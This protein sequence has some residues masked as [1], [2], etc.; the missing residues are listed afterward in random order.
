MYVAR[1]AL[2]RQVLPQSSCRIFSRSNFLGR[3]ARSGPISLLPSTPARTRFAPSPT[4]YVHIGSL[5]TALF[6]Y[7]LAKA[8][9][10]QFLVRVEDT[11]QVRPDTLLILMVNENK[12]RSD[13]WLETTRAR[14]RGEVVRRFELGR[15]QLGRRWEILRRRTRLQFSSHPNIIQALILEDLTD[16]ISR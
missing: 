4:G 8:T 16:R 12:P 6:N 5:R 11:D 10:G 7:L 3:P 1:G 13:S 15:P 9:G 2:R 14:C